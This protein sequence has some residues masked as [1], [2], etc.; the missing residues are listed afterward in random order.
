MMVVLTGVICVLTVL[1]IF[2]VGLQVWD[3]WHESGRLI[4]ATKEIREALIKAVERNDENMRINLAQASEAMKRNDEQSRKALEAAIQNA[5]MDTRAWVG[6]VTYTPPRCV[7]N[8]RPT[9]Y[10]AGCNAIMGVNIV[11]SGKSIATNYR[12]MLGGILLPADVPFRAHYTD[13]PSRSVTVLQPG[14]QVSSYTAPFS[15]PI[16]QE[17][18]EAVRTGKAM[19]YIFGNLEY[20]DIFGLRHFGKF[21]GYLTQDLVGI[22]SCPTYNE[23]N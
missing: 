13:P 20:N 16:T 5:R 9:F 22:E 17:M 3:N 6:V 11:N 8:N 1:N 15:K 10:A 12:L 2:V 14:M 4:L 7:E 19:V 18:V 23:A 21:C